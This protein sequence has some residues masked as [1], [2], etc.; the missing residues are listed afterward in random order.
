MVFGELLETDLLEVKDDVC[1][2]FLDPGDSI[3]FM[4]DTVNTDGVNSKATQRREQDA[5][6]CITDCLAITGLEGA[7][8][9][10]SERIIVLEHDDLI[11]FLKC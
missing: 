11:G 1:Y 4:R 7:D 2:I 10:L 6:E 9:E 3:Q 8:F 5:S